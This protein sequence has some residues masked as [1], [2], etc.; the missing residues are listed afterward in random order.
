MQHSHSF[1]DEKN[2]SCIWLTEKY[3]V[4]VTD[5][6]KDSVA[7]TL[8]DCSRIYLWSSVIALGRISFS[9]CRAVHISLIFLDLKISLLLFIKNLTKNLTIL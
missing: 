6:K 4:I 7:M 8:K 2:I 5:C 9:N 1:P 3:R